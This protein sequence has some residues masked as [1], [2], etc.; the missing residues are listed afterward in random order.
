MLNKG[1]FLLAFVAATGRHLE[2][3]D[4]QWAVI[5]DLYFD[6]PIEFTNYRQFAQWIADHESEVSEKLEA[7]MAAVEAEIARHERHIQRLRESIA[8]VVRL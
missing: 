6:S 2:L 8:P 5:K 1:E 4:A 3:N 7:K